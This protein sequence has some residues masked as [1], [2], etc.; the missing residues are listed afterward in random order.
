M[1]TVR[2]EEP[3]GYESLHEAKEIWRGPHPDQSIDPNRPVCVDVGQAHPLMF[4]TGRVFVMNAAGKTVATYV[5][6]WPPMAQ[7]V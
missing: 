5:F 4:C 1:F 2:H 3:N 7:P 6:D